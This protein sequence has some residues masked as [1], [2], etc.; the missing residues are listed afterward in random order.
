MVL[1][2]CYVIYVS[3]CLYRM[4]ACHFP[5]MHLWL[6]VAPYFPNTLQLIPRRKFFFSSFFFF[7]RLIFGSPNLRLYIIDTWHSIKSNPYMP[8]HKK[9]LKIKYESNRDSPRAGPFPVNSWCTLV[10]RFSLAWVEASSIAL[11]YSLMCL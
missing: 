8:C 3:V 1:L 2:F 5:L 9:E 6:V 7:A 11:F 4:L 10:T